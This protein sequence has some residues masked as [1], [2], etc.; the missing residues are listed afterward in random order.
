LFGLLAY[1]IIAGKAAF[2]A[3]TPSPELEDNILSSKY[4]FTKD[5]SADAKDLI[6]KLIIV[7]A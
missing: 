4:E 1:E 3:D 6:S 5:F 7:N 2:P